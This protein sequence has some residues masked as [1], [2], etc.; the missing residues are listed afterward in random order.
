MLL[1][2]AFYAA[3]ARPT[4]PEVSRARGECARYR[5]HVEKLEADPKADPAQLAR[6]TAE[7]ERACARAEALMQDAGVEPRSPPPQEPPPPAQIVIE[8][9]APADPPG[10]VVIDEDPVPPT[11]PE[12]PPRP[13]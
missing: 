2:P 8:G 11:M 12:A 7:W 10:D 5:R 13:Y 1:A 3:D 9:S 4:A 6:D